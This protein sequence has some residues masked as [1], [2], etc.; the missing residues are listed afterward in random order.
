MQCFDMKNMR[1]SSKFV[2]WNI[3][4]QRATLPSEHQ[5]KRE[6]YKILY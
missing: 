5:Q 3:L 4:W 6:K 1:L 2:P